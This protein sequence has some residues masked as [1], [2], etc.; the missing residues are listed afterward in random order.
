MRPL[1]GLLS[2]AT[3][4]AWGMPG[5]AQE[6]GRSL[7][8][9]TAEVNGTAHAADRSPLM[10]AARTGEARID[11]STTR[12]ANRVSRMS[13]RNPSLPE[14]DAIKRAKW[15]AKVAS[16]RGGPVEQGQPKSVT[17]AIGVDFEANW[18][19]V[20]T[21]PDNTVA[22][23]NGGKIV[24][25]NNDGIELYNASGQFL[26]STFWPDFF[27]DPQLNANIY[28]P[29]VLYDPQ[30]DRFF[31]TVLHGTTSS[32]SKLLLCFSKT[33]D[34]Q[35]GW[36]TYQL[37]GNPLGNGT[38]FDYPS[39]GVSNNEVYVSG[40]L[41]TDGNNQFQQAIL[42]QITKSGGYNGDA[43]L[44]WIYWYN[45]SNQPYAAFT[46]VPVSGGQANY[47]PG[48]L[49]LSGNSPGASS[50]RLWDLTDDLTGSPALNT[51]DVSTQQYAPAAPAQM[52]GSSDPLSNGDCRMLST[53]FMNGLVHYTFCT[54]I[55]GGWNGL[56][57][58]RIAINNLSDQRTNLGQQGNADL[59]YP[60]LASYSTSSSDP[61]VMIVFTRSSAQVY[62]EVRVVN[63]DATMQWSNST[64]VK[65][66]ET[67]V[68]F[69]QQG[70]ERWGDYSGM[71]RRH[72]A[73]P[74]RVWLA[75]CYGSNIQ[76]GLS[77]TWKTWVAEVGDTGSSTIT[78]TPTGMQVTVAPNPTVDLF[79]LSFHVD[80]FA[81]YTIEVLDMNGRLVK[82][83]YHDGL[84][85][86]DHQLSFNRNALSAGQYVIAIRNGSN[87]IAHEPLVIH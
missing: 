56:R 59:C 36:W 35:A 39:I 34:P 72:N 15:P 48:I 22:I 1:G 37:P 24:T 83:L 58:G 87:R 23:S 43:N 85:A 42:F 55:G 11:M 75:A 46:V 12:W 86:G 80:A 53:F 7:P 40:N 70:D 49:L 51:Y 13:P 19:Q 9:P 82:T 73:N 71:A 64:L 44:N 65:Q 74:P 3:F 18:S 17:P 27:N 29:K 16:Y 14:V 33:N 50:L 67:F 76:G 60:A 10:T 2:L 28:D 47:G 81:I 25:C 32:T 84:T 61:S 6:V 38:W 26:S 30:A 5:T 4:L 69:L 66:G 52:P 57:Y 54:D 31:L 78:E 62:P 41:F 21:P 20:S 68:N 8:A 77:N 45:L 63:V 79:R